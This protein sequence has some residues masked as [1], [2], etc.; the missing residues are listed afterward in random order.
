MRQHIRRIL[1]PIM[2]PR[3]ISGD[4]GT[5]RF[6]HGTMR[7]DR[8]ALCNHLIAARRLNSYLEIGCRNK[9]DMND[10]ILARRVSSVDPDPAARAEY[11]MT[12][13]DYFNNHDERFD[14]IFIDGLH[15]GEQVK[16][17]ISNS[18][19]ALNPGG[20]ILLHDM[21]PPTELHAR[22]ENEVNGSFPAWNG[23]S[24]EGFAWHRKYSPQ[25]EMYVVDADWGVGVVRPGAQVL[26]NGP[27]QG[28]A[29]LETSRR[30][31][32]NLITVAEF[33]KRNPPVIR[34]EWV[35]R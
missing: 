18:L 5:Y 15:I 2:R 29:A 34:E 10:R 1:T 35:P 19:R 17:D 30:E 7:T 33:L 21:N 6:A 24:W 4:C 28:F 26:W 16:R 9:A 27:T 22:E 31:I 11:C 25:L 13:D 20:F 32:L 3:A 8:V 14:L 23:T 12:S